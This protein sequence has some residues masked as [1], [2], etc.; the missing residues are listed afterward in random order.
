M[1]SAIQLYKMD[2][3]DVDDDHGP[4]VDKK[5]NSRDLDMNPEY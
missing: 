2:S 4:D 1:T 3:H 5:Q